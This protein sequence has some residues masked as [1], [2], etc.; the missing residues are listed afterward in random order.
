MNIYKFFVYCFLFCLAGR[1]GQAQDA[2]KTYAYNE[3][4]CSLSFPIAPTTAQE[5]NVWTAQAKSENTVYQ[6]VVY[7]NK[8]YNGIQTEAVLKES[9]EGFINPATDKIT[10]QE[11][12]QMHGCPAQKIQIQSQDGTF[13]VFCTWVGKGKLYQMAVAGTNP[14]Q[15]ISKAQLF[16]DGL[17]M[18]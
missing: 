6:V 1:Q 14:A 15:T 17:K 4:A 5:D 7:L 11:T 3:V 2:W 10:K 16:L 8:D 9:L 12:L 13:L 18:R